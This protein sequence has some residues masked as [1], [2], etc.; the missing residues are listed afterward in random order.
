MKTDQIKNALRANPAA[1]VH[2]NFAP[3]G[4]WWADIVADG[5]VLTR[6]GYADTCDGAL[7]EL[8]RLLTPLKK[9]PKKIVWFVA[10][11]PSAFRGSRGWPTA[12]Y[13]KDGPLCAVIACG[14]GY[15]AER[16]RTGKHSPLTVS[17][18]DYSNNQRR[19]KCLQPKATLAEAKAWVEK[20]LESFPSFKP[21]S[22][23]GFHG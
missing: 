5:K 12:Y 17:I 23:D 16:A 20:M 7:I 14:D 18:V 22:E 10:T 8:E 11:P 4:S 15:T 1:T 19:Q 13:G 9:L 21:S 3:L 2:L 6:G